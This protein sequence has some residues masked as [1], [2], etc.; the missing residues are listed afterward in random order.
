M[1]KV[2]HLFSSLKGNEAFLAHADSD[3]K[4]ASLH[5]LT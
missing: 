3:L 2:V 1:Q 4:V 5:S